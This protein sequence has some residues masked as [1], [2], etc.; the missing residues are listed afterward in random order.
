[1]PDASLRFDLPGGVLPE[2]VDLIQDTWAE[3]ADDPGPYILAGLGQLC[4]LIPVMIVLF[5]LIY[6]GIFATV[7]GGVFVGVFAAALVG[8][9]VGPEAGAITFMLAYIVSFLM[10]F[11]VIIG[12]S[13]AV[14]AVMA[15]INASLTRRIAQHQRGQRPLDFT[16]AF[17]DTG[18]DLVKVILFAMTSSAIIFIGI[19]ACY[20]PGLIAAFLLVYAGTFVYLH[21]LSPLEA[22]MASAGHFREHLQFHGMFTLLYFCVA[23][24]ASYIPVAGPMFVASLHVRAHRT[25][26]GDGEEP[27][28]EPRIIEAT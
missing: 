2:P 10:M 25:L 6:F 11:L 17:S 1:M 15:P 14:G 13:S 22:I 27:V 16:A 4:V 19:M 20:L 12:I 9:V 5:M 18:Q 21:R 3:F 28:F 23:M 8:E 24:V 7:F 26:F